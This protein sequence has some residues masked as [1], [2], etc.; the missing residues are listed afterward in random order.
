LVNSPRAKLLY[1]KASFA[2]LSDERSAGLYSAAE[3]QAIAAH[4]P[5]TRRL[6]ERKT[7]FDGL[8][9]DLVPFIL[10]HRERMVLKPNDDYGGKGI[11]L[12]W[13]TTGPEWEAAVVRGL[14]S[15]YVVQDRVRLPSE[16]YPALD[17]G[18]LVIAPRLVDT[19][20]YGLHGE[21][22]EGCLTRISTEDLVN[23]TAGGGSTVPTF[24][25][26]PR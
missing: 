26:E 2:V 25:V 13:K 12:G 22:M 16:D 21:F 14:Q 7:E 6:A 11:V 1:K 5:W 17:D 8:A 19:D 10:E 24:L 3:R 20:P 9:I 18:R 4:I 23:V 15:D